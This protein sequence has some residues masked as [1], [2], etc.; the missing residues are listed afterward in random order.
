[1]CLLQGAR[2]RQTCQRVLPSELWGSNLCVSRAD[3]G[4]GHPGPLLSAK[5]WQQQNGWTTTSI[6]Q[7][8]SLPT[9]AMSGQLWLLVCRVP[10][11][12]GDTS[13]ESYPVQCVLTKAPAGVMVC[14]WC[15]TLAAGGICLP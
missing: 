2:R 13:K 9:D 14:A 12:D 11:C 7:G 1:M 4:W 5:T 15:Q 8:E 3:E 6:Q 10:A